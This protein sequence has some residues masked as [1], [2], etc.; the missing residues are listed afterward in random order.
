MLAYEKGIDVSLVMHSHYPSYHGTSKSS[1]VCFVP[2]V[3]WQWEQPRGWDRLKAA[4]ALEIFT[5]NQQQQTF[6]IAL[7]NETEATSFEQQPDDE[8]TQA[9]RD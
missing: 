9:A 5:G 2:G 8:A 4:K 7:I 1:C 6:D 3:F